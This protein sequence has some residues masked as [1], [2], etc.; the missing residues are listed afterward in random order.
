METVVVVTVGGVLGVGVPLLNK[1]RGRS[2]FGA[3]V[4]FS[5]DIPFRTRDV[6]SW[7]IL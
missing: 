3:D 1:G 2:L 6:G 4:A 5:H 7:V